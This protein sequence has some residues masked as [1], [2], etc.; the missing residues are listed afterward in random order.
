MTDTLYCTIDTL[1]VGEEERCKAQPGAIR[2]AIEEEIRTVEGQANWRCAAVIRDARNTDRI[3]VVRIA[4]SSSERKGVVGMCGI[5]QDTFGIVQN[6]EP[7]RYSVTLGRRTEQNPYVA[8]LAVIATG[9]KRLPLD[10]MGRQITIFSNNQA[11]LL[12]VSQ[13]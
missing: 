12:A 10:L 3:K 2:K 5:I 6:G 11:A 7:I 1:R 9:V 4:T 8:E 13:P